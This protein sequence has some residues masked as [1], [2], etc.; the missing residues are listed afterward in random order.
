MAGVNRFF[1]HCRTATAAALTWIGASS[2]GYSA[3]EQPAPSPG[4]GLIIARQ[5]CI[6]CHVVEDSADH[7]V[8]VGVPSF[9][10]I[11]NKQGQTAQHIT[12]ILIKPHPPMPDMHLSSEEILNIIAY[13][14]TLRI[15]KTQPPLL[16]LEEQGSKPVYPEPS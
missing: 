12:N 16:P 1:L 10:G 9:R 8:P 2:T 11:A 14:Q 15:D 4:K 7:P 13:L 6:G 5:F 3:D